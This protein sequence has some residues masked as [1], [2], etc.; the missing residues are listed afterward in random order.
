MWQFPLGAVLEPAALASEAGTGLW[1]PASVSMAADSRLR[2]GVAWLSSSVSQGVESFLL[3]A[4]WRR[5][6]GYTIGVSVARAAVSGLVRT[7][8]DPT[9]VGTIDYSSSLIS[10]TVA[11]QVLPRLTVG[12]SA[13]YR[14]GRNDLRKGS[15]IAGDLGL[16]MDSL[17]SRHIRIGLSSFLWRPGR[18]RDD[19]PIFLAAADARLFARKEMPDIR[20]GYSRGATSGGAREHGPFMSA[21]TGPLEVRGALVITRAYGSRDLRAR[22]G[23]ALHLRRYIVGIGREEGIGGLGPLYQFTLSSLVK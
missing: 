19:L 9:S 2:V 13:R 22:S 6:S 20:L 15:A 8:S 11:R 17:T 10:A 1:N 14:D 7:E 4:S 5:P 12:L 21:Q 23:L 16:R 3:G 18:E